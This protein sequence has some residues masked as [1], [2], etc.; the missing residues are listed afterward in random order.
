MI[1]QR[2]I[3]ALRSRSWSTLLLELLVLTLSVFLAFQVDRWYEAYRENQLVTDYLTRLVDDL[4]ADIDAL[5]GVKESSDL[6]AGSIDLLARSLT[7]PDV[8]DEDPTLFIIALEQAIY[9]FQLVVTDATYQE[10]LSTGHMSL[11]PSETRALLYAYYGHNA[12]FSQFD[13]AINTIQAQAFDRFA[14]IVTPELFSP[15]LLNPLKS[16]RRTYTKEEARAAAARFWRNERAVAWL[17]RLRQ[18]QMQIGLQSEWTRG[19]A[20]SL[21][22]HLDE[23]RSPTKG[24]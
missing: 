12:Q 1:F 15:F 4:Q 16:E 22:D 7:N 24:G 17:G 10:L 3:K 9:R 6:R 13:P 20:L 23:L 8:V 14:G 19:I 21:I 11:L 2:L 18:T 5:A